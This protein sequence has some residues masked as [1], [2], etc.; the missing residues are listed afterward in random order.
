MRILHE[1]E[2]TL[3]IVIGDRVR[4]VR[5]SRVEVIRGDIDSS[6]LVWRARG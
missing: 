3:C 1:T 5:G 6:R 2:R 4:A